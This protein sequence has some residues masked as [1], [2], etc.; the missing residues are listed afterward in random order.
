M[1]GRLSVAGVDADDGIAGTVVEAVDGGR[2]DAFR[3]VGG[4]IGLQP[5]G[6]APLQAQRVA[7]SDHDAGTWK[8]R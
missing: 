5:C 8:P 4:M 7:E 3:V 6:E 1:L 2:Q